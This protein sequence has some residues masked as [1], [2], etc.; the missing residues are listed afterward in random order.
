MPARFVGQ[1]LTAF[2]KLRLDSEIGALK[3]KYNVVTWS[4]NLIGAYQ[5]RMLAL[6]GCGR[7]HI[8]FQDYVQVRTQIQGKY[9]VPLHKTSTTLEYRSR[10]SKRGWI[11]F[12]LRRHCL[13]A[14]C[15]SISFAASRT[16]CKSVVLNVYTS[17][18]DSFLT[19]LSN[20]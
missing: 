1:N 10:P 7:L 3:L 8:A 12:I 5:V 11:R 20:L 13:A 17:S 16:P 4:I 9:G 14:S 19:V 2:V 6:L 15:L 18:A